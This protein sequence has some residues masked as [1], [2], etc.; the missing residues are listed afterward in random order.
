MLM[1]SCDTNEKYGIKEYL[2]LNNTNYEL[3]ILFKDEF[4]N[5]VH[6]DSVSLNSNQD[7]TFSLEWSD[8]GASGFPFFYEVDSTFAIF[9]NVK[10]IK[11]ALGGSETNNKNIYNFNTYIIEELNSDK[12]NEVNNRYTFEFTEQDY[13]LADTL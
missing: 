4:N 12:K 1:Y 5:N 3:K 10:I 8:N 7:T 9:G 2:I 6:Y 11:Y 13:I